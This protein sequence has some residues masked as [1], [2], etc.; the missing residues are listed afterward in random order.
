MQ[1]DRLHSKDFA[2]L[3]V[4]AFGFLAVVFASSH[5]TAALF[6]VIAAVLDGLDGHLARGRGKANDFGRELDSLADAVA[7]GAAPAF[8]V[9][10][11]FRDSAFV[12]LYAG[13]SVVFLSACII[14][15]ARFNLY[16]AEHHRTKPGEKSVYYGLPAPAAAVML[17][18]LSPIFGVFVPALA[19]MLGGL[20][21]AGFEI[22]KPGF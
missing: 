13:A 3:G 22:K 5:W 1:F 16:A 19:L 4:G 17:A 12:W 6:V 18:V 11:P 15:L 21:L 8:L 9:F 7:F 14:R 2:T 10:W 20:M